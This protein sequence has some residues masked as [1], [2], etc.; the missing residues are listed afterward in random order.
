MKQIDKLK[1]KARILKNEIIAI[2]IALKD[3]RTPLY[4]KLLIGL[5]I[6]YALSPIDLIPDF[7]PLLGYLDD[8]II[9]PLMI[10]TSIKM[11]PADVLVECRK[12]ARENNV[13][14]KKSGLIAAFFIILI[15]MWLTGIIILKLFNS[16]ISA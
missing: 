14:N 9:L 3:K 8:L 4:A 6:G 1:D 5:T 12:Y 2:S 11:I 10:M 16:N 13:L 7:I 15:W